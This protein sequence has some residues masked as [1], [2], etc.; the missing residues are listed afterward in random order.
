MRWASNRFFIL[1]DVVFA[2]LGELIKKA[3][4]RSI[5][6]W[7]MNPPSHCINL[8]EGTREACELR[9]ILPCLQQT[10]PVDL[11]DSEKIR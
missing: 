7:I 8:D 11:R 10:P 2:I 4:P 6:S 3:P 1:Q 9:P 5:F